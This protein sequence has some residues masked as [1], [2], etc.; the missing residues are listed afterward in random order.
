MKILR[1]FPNK[2]NTSLKGTFSIEV[3][4]WHLIINDMKHFESNGRKWVSFPQKM[5]GKGPEAKYFPFIQFNDKALQARFI[6]KVL[7]LLEDYLKS[8]PIKPEEATGPSQ[9]ELPF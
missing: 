5:T 2:G 7:P 3:D 1:Y 9:G 4:K 6:D 8:S